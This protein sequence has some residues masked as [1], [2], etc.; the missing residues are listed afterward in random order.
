[1]EIIFAH[2]DAPSLN[3][4]TC[5][6]S[7]PAGLYASMVLV[8]D[9]ALFV[10]TGLSISVAYCAVILVVIL[11]A[12]L[13]MVP[14]HECISVPLPTFKKIAANILRELVRWAFCRLWGSFPR[15]PPGQWL[16]ILSEGTLVWKMSVRVVWLFGGGVW[17]H[18]PS[19]LVLS[20]S[21]AVLV[22]PS[23]DGSSY[24]FMQ[25]VLN[26]RNVTLL[27]QQ[28]GLCGLLFAL[29]HPCFI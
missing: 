24:I 23:L 7:E 19:F 8:P 15:F 14:W 20:V 25:R 2:A 29:L 9:T 28:K 27:P 11:S 26:G 4:P 16:S 12:T 6:R 18:W 10:I 3:S 5:S 1:M 13:C 22:L 17:M 21:K